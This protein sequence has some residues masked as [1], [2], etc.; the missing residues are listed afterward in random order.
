MQVTSIKLNSANVKYDNS[1]DTEKTY[2]ISA[3]VNIN[4]T[5]VSS[6]NDGYVLFTDTQVAQFNWYGKNHLNV[7]YLNVEIS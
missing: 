3:N 6:I 2:D 5:E 4:N 7:T 1:V